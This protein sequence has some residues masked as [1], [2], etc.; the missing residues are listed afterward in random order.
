MTDFDSKSVE[1]DGPCRFA[2]KSLSRVEVPAKIS[3]N[4]SVADWM[5][6]DFP[7][8]PVLIDASKTL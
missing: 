8:R 7:H 3:Q 6:T 5:F 1:T 2:Y 4:R